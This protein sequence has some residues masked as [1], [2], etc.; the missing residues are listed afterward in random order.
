MHNRRWKIQDFCSVWLCSS[1]SALH[2]TPQLRPSITKGKHLT[3]S[4][5]NCQVFLRRFERPLFGLNP[6]MA[7]PFGLPSAWRDG[8][9]NFVRIHF[10]S[11]NNKCRSGSAQCVRSPNRNF[12]PVSFGLVRRPRTSILCSKVL[13]AQVKLAD[14]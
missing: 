1:Q 12:P 8:S 10:I 13:F 7:I 14:V 3:G 11:N 5:M 2:N 4:R 6:N 9:G